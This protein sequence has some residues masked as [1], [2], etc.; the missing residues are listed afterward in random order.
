[1]FTSTEVCRLQ[2]GTF[3][4]VPLYIR[5]RQN[6]PKRDVRAGLKRKESSEALLLDSTAV[7][8]RGMLGQLVV[9]NSDG[10]P[11]VLVH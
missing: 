2:E 4:P 11:R 8:D 5:I 9:D 10:F 6:L 1:M 7:A 3:R